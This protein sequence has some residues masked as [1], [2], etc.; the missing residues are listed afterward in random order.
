MVFEV[1]FGVKKRGVYTAQKVF[2]LTIY[3]TIYCDIGNYIPIPPY[4]ALDRCRRNS[5]PKI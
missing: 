3:S 4:P 1:V 5:K 2:H